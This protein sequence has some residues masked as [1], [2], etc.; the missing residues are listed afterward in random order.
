MN[1]ALHDP[2]YRAQQYAL[3]AE[4]ATNP[5][6]RQKYQHLYDLAMLLY[7]SNTHSL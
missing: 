6:E 3:Y 7:K 4:R 2:L 5:T 1:S